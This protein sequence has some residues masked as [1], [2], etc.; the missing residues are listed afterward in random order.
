MTSAAVCVGDIVC[1]VLGCPS[2]M[3]LR[4]TVSGHHCVVGTAYLHGRID[5]ES[6]LGPLPQGYNIE[7]GTDAGW[8]GG[9][10]YRDKSSGEVATEDP[11]LGDIPPD[12][13]KVEATRR[14]TD[15]LHFARY[16]HLGDGRIIN[17]DPRLLPKMLISRGVQLIEFRLV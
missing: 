13:V 8:Y 16:R 15:P 17:S 12:W 5:A 4:P 2:P 10:N 14:P 3:I 9:F 11:R 1:V 7:I 6:L